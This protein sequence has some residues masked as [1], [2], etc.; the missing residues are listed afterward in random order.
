[1]SYDEHYKGKLIS[2]GKT[3]KEY[4]PNAD[5]VGDCVLDVVEI[6]DIVFESVGTPVADEPDI[7][8]ATLNEDGSYN[9]EVK[10]YNGCMSF[11]GAIGKAIDRLK[12]QR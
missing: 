12:E 5:C 1:M 4:D 10:Y 7:F 9:F 3:L 11:Q 2:T 6:D 8:R